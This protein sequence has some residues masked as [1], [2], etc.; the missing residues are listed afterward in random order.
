MFGR[1]DFADLI[2]YSSN[3]LISALSKIIENVNVSQALNLKS[4][5]YVVQCSSVCNKPSKW[6]WEWVEPEL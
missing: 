6:I 3:F 4:V 5:G 2:M 1:N